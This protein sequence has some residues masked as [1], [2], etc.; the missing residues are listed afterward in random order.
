MKVKKL[1]RL[2]YLISL[3]LFFLLVVLAPS[4]LAVG[5]PDTAGR[6]ETVTGRPSN[7]GNSATGVQE[8]RRQQAQNRLTEAKLKVC[9]A[10]ENAIKKRTQQLT[11]LATTM[12]EKFDAI[13]GRVE[14][15]YTSKVVPNGKTVANYDNLVADIQAKK[16]A[17][18]IALTTAQNNAGTF[19]CDGNDPKGQLTQFRDDVRIVKAALK[20]YRTSIKN[21]IV[22]VRSVTGTTERTNPS[23]SPKPTGNE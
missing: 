13:A 3:S 19:A 11:K 12:Q 22:A 15:Y 16:G 14:E 8:K 1:G 23:A 2:Q 7:V 18:Q 5:K 20:D 4:V 9:Q 6:P 21:L 10:K 17:V